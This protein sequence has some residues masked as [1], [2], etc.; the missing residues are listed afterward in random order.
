[1]NTVDGYLHRAMAALACLGHIACFYNDGEADSPPPDF[2]YGLSVILNWIED[3]VTQA[4][5]G[6]TEKGEEKPE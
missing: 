6:L 4:Y 5:N 1:M 3:E 2:G